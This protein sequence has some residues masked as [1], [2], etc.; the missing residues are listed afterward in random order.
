M[1]VR[2]GSRGSRLALDAGRGRRRPRCG[3]PGHEIALVPDDDRGRP[4]PQEPVR[5][6]RRA[7]RVREGDRGG[8]AR[9]PDRRRRPLG[10]GHDLDRHRGSRGR[11]LPRARRPARRADR[12]R[13][14]PARHAHRHGVRAPQARSC[15]PSSR[16]SR[17][18]R[19]AATST[20]ACAR[21][22]SAGSTRS[23]SPACGL[24]RLGLADEIGLRIPVDTMLPE[25]AQGA[26]A[27]QVRA[28]EEELV[29]HA[30]HAETRR[31][32]RGR[33]RVRRA[34]RGGLPRAGRGAPRRRPAGRA[35][36][37]RGRLVARAPHAATDPAALAAAL[38]AAAGKRAA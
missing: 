10:E 33:A 27:L 6:D 8:A 26:L 25:A 35:D 20:R 24:D 30:D 16:R 11:R 31:Q 18:S 9:G 2:I 19:C 4:R 32:R 37:G 14:D 12:R 23:C 36:R 1:L 15:S 34:G 3:R 13:R 29:A 17:S 22:G 38:I 5:P 21:R 28:G 7:R